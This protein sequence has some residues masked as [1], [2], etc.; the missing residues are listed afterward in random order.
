[1]KMRLPSFAYSENLKLPEEPK[2]DPIPDNIPLAELAEQ[3]VRGKVK[4]TPMQQ[5]MLIELL[6]FHM[7]KLSAVAVGRLTGEDFASRL[8]RAVDASNRATK[9]IEAKVI[10]TEL[11]Q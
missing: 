8:D 10:S 11:D 4:L 3:V 1:M 7:P 2:S 9:L 6:P 5:R